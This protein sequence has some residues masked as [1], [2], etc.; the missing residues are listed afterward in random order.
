MVELIDVNKMGSVAKIEGSGAKIEGSGA[1]IEGSG[2]KMGTTG[3]KT[4]AVV[5]P[6]QNFQIRRT[7]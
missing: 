1:K 4:G 7:L 6:A 5:L 3:V 2:A